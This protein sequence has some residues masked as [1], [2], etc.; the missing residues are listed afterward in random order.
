V[1]Q[2]NTMGDPPT[3]AAWS[4]ATAAHFAAHA[5]A[6]S[7]ESR[8]R[9]A[10]NPLRILDS[11]EPEDRALVIAAPKI[12]VFMTSEAGAFFEA[13]Q[14]GLQAAG[15]AWE[16]NPRLV[17]GLDYYRHTVFEFVTSALGAQGT[18][19]GGGRYD[20]LIGTMGGPET[21]AVGWAGGIERLAMLLTEPP[22]QAID[23]VVIPDHPDMEAEA[24]L[25]IAA[26]RRGGVSVATAYRGNAKRR[27]EVAAKA[28]PTALLYVRNAADQAQRLHLVDKVKDAAAAERLLR[29]TAALPEPYRGFDTDA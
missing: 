14:K 12:D 19:I 18:V 23:V 4:A 26:L 9:L 10:I 5:D 7:E 15:V 8:K 3:R 6:L 13:L 16:A 28:N 29:I 2:L 21:P 22:V 20:G 11:K 24:E 25:I 17:R 27:A 1:L